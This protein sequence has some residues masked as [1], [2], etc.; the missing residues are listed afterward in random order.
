[1]VAIAV[2]AFNLYE[3]VV[4]ILNDHKDDEKFKNFQN[5]DNIF[6]AS[7]ET[8]VASTIMAYYLSYIVIGTLLFFFGIIFSCGAYK[9]NL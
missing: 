7:R 2:V 6:G 5:L 9:V 8:L 1:M 3:L 4:N